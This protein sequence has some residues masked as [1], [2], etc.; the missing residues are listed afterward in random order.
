MNKFVSV[1]ASVC[2]AGAFAPCAWSQN[3]LKAGIKS[4]RPAVQSSSILGRLDA[5]VSS[6]I[7]ALNRSRR[8][9]VVTGKVPLR[10]QAAVHHGF[11]SVILRP[12][13]PSSPA[14]LRFRLVAPAQELEVEAIQTYNQ[15]FADFSSFRKEADAVVGNAL[16]EGTSV[17]QVLAP[18]QINYFT[19][20][21]LALEFRLGKLQRVWFPTDPSLK[22]VR[23]YI[24]FTSFQFN[25][26]YTPEMPDVPSYAARPFSEEE[27][28][29]EY[30]WLH[31]PPQEEEL[32]TLP[33]NVRLAV[34]NDNPNILHMYKRWEK[35][36]YFPK[37][38]TVSAYQ[39]AR[40]LLKAVNSGEKFGL[41][42]SDMV[43]PGGGGR[44]FVSQL[45]QRDELTPVIGCSMY[46]RSDL[47]PEELHQLGFDGYMCGDYMFDSPDGFYSWSL[48]IKNY[49]YHKRVGKYRR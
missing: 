36:G 44:Y 38:W 33:E 1:L 29:M 24:E 5:R 41:I 34:L 8:A 32:R 6:G 15:F 3:I 27:F 14:E 39:D 48:Y 9:A 10:R 16:L 19:E 20:Q 31:K 28:W 22:M 17:Q 30:D 4:V 2:C 47:K 18:A 45:R 21:L 11:E 40:D 25:K 13:V 37:G 46:E 23:E 7:E 35:E 42:I 12:V 43:V 26:F 49:Y